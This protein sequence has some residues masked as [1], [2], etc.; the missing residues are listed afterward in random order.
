MR[1]GLAL[2]HYDYSFPDGGPATFDRVADVARRAE[3]LGFHS[4][5]MSDHFYLSL[6][7]YGG[8]AEKHGTLEP[9]TAL[10]GIA[11]LTERVRLGT[12][13]LCAQFR[14]PGI[15]AKA[16]TVVDLVSGGRLDLGIGAG[17][18][19]DEFEDFGLGFPATAE[20]FARLE[21][22]FEVLGLLFGE[23]PADFDGRY[24]ELRG[25][26]NRPRSSQTPR[27]PLWLGAKG[28]PRALRLAA[29]SADGWNV[30][31][32]IA[33]EEY[34]AR[35]RDADR[36]CERVGRDPETLRRSVGLYTL[37]GENERDLASRFDALRR[38]TPGGALDG[39]RLEAYGVDTLTGTPQRI[40][41]RVGAFSDLGVEEIVVCLA[42]IPFAVYDMSMLDLFA[43]SVIAPAVSA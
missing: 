38:W 15:L 28:G 33:P 22:T 26:Y 3:L 24:F 39:T 18:Y 21:E 35:A 40:L 43:E 5:W 37:V 17:W 13:V 6:A 2:P 12:L 16:A 34:V 41:D 10:A 11:S 30:V 29:R 9:L 19:E 23:G 32:R 4:V 25:A 7:R 14:H 36:A 20:R 27:P 31:W 1:F 8:G 42:P